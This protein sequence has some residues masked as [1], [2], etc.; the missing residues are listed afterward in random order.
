[1][2]NT[3]LKNIV[4]LTCSTATTKVK[5]LIPGVNLYFCWDVD[6]KEVASPG[7]D[8]TYINWELWYDI[9]PE[10]IN[11]DDSDYLTLKSIGLGPFKLTIDGTTKTVNRDANFHWGESIGYSG[12]M[13]SGQRAVDC[14]GN[15]YYDAVTGSLTISSE[16]WLNYF[17]S[18]GNDGIGEDDS[19]SS[20]WKTGTF[21]MSSIPRKEPKV[22]VS[23]AT[24][25]TDEEN[26]VI[27]YNKTYLAGQNS[28]DKLEACISFTGAEDDI[29]Y[30][31]VPYNFT[32]NNS[33]TASYTFM[34]TD[35][36]RK[37]LRQKAKN[38]VN[39]VRFYIKTTKYKTG[40]VFWHY[41]D[42]NFTIVNGEPTLNPAIR[43]VN[44]RTLELTGNANKLIRYYSDVYFDTG[45]VAKKEATIASQYVTNGSKTIR[46][47]STG[48]IEDIDSN[49]F[50][51]GMTDSRNA[52]VKD[53][54][55][56]DL[57]PYTKLTA[58]IDEAT[59]DVNGNLTFT[60]KGNYYDGSFGARNNS[61]EVEYSLQE[62][63]GDI[64]WT[65]IEPAI[66]SSSGTYSATH[67]IEGL[68]YNSKYT[69]VVNVIDEVTS[70]QTNPKVIS[71]NPVFDWSE[72]DF[73]HNTDVYLNIDT[74]LIG[75]DVNNNELEM[76]QV[77]SEN[78]KVVLADSNGY[79]EIKGETINL[80]TDSLMLNGQGLG[81]NNK[82][83]W[84]GESHLNG[85]QSA[86]LSERVSAQA[87]G[88]VLVFS[89]YRNGAAENVSINSFFVSKKEVELLE[90]A[91]HS[92]FMLIN[93]GFSVIG[94]KYL[95]IYD[96]AIAGH[97]TNTSSSA[98]N[99]I[100][101]NNSMFVLRY[102]IG[103]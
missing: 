32:L 62:N 71:S 3:T 57:V 68:Q 15:G 91:P 95:Y 51:F 93:S 88:I 7:V 1:M 31:E 84:S 52:S 22:W 34:L 24:N 92:F 42:R 33:N 41:L 63:D 50:Y 2:I 21:S 13:A 65:I 36:E 12:I 67:T 40:E 45:A 86:V 76:A 75:Y 19:V 78:R 43:D 44:A 81:G 99:G 58:Y 17:D 10:E 80:I 61:L 6:E 16:L 85:N 83:L 27:Y 94:A 90:G 38:G 53:F 96:N 79:T 14:D 35:E 20:S 30:R 98:N 59:L 46:D 73:K 55:V 64:N 102:V 23:D 89:L 72:T 11:S 26:P 9:D 66:N 100:T 8:F 69:L 87:N 18:E 56:V 97:E 103:V 28:N 49:T 37:T 74:K 54:I 4:P 29:P 60:V 5:K 48:I 82:V 25:F 39:V 77:D 47:T 70:I 101:F